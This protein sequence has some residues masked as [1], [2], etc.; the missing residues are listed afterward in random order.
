MHKY[1]SNAG[2]KNY[3]PPSDDTARG[4]IVSKSTPKWKSTVI[5]V[6]VVITVL[7]LIIAAIVCLMSDENPA[8]DEFATTQAITETFDYDELFK[9]E[10]TV[11]EE[12]MSSSENSNFSEEKS[13]IKASE[14][15]SIPESLSSNNESKHNVSNQISSSNE[16]K[17]NKKNSSESS[18]NINRNSISYSNNNSNQSNNSNQDNNTDYN[19]NSNSN[20]NNQVIDNTPKTVEVNS[21]SISNSN[22]TITVGKTTTLSASVSPSNATNKSVTWSSGNNSV[23][24]VNKGKVTA[25]NVG[26]TQIYAISNNGIKAICNV[27]VKDKPEEVDN[28]CIIPESKTIKIGQTVTVELKGAKNCTWNIS[29]PFVVNEVSKQ[30]TK[31][32]VRGAKK[33]IT[34]VEAV[35]PNGK[36]YKAKITVQ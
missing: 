24:A 34:N 32:T 29:N 13:E 28:V 30:N 17:A 27:T 19:Y 23:V 3:E 10:T 21:V 11:S 6:G 2:F 26:S 36:T 14:T 16:E 15:K 31:I 12:E 5:L 4:D 20:S 18:N 8:E 9:T 1:K 25:L 22:I 35:L 7:F 33:G